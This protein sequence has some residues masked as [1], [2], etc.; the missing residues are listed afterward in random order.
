MKFNNNHMAYRQFLDKFENG[1]ENIDENLL[2]AKALAKETHRPFI[3]INTLEG[4]ANSPFFTFNKESVK[5][6]I[7]L[8]YTKL[9]TNSFLYRVFTY[10]PIDFCAIT[11]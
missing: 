9:K 7:I 8:A 10:I 1:L 5:P 4:Q 11:F 2:L 6:P 3:F